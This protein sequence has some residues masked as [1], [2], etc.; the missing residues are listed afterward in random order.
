M[1]LFV[2]NTLL[3]DVPLRTIFRGVWPFIIAQLLCLALLIAFPQAS[4]WLA[5]RVR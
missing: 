5:N 2:L 4:L 3:P 1:N